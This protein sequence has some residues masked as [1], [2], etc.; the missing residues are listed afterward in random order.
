MN[1]DPILAPGGRFHR[2]VVIKRSRFIGVVIPFDHSI[3]MKDLIRSVQEEF[4][5]ATHYCW[6]Y[7]TR[8]PRLDEGSSD[9]GEPSGTAGRPILNAILASGTWQ[10]A[11]VVVRYF[12]GIKL[13]VRGLI[14]AYN[15]SAAEALEA[16]PKVTL[17][18][19][20][21]VTLRLPYQ[22]EDQLRYW[23]AR[24]GLSPQALSWDYAQDLTVRGILPSALL[25]QLRAFMDSASPRG[26]I[27]IQLGE[28]VL[29]PSP[30][31]A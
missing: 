26:E 4:P 22:K 2:E 9:G 11:V 18:E 23:W 28:A 13:G 3:P 20:V 16:C 29:A 8:W 1:L 24:A 6:A 21:P 12:G 27:Q 25:D 31:E 19:C 10:A 5:R 17:E 7:R 30:R 14:D 15:L